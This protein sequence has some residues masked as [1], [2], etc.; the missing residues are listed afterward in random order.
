MMVWKRLAALAAALVA[1]GGVSTQASAQATRTWVSGVGDDVNPC[2]RTAPCK[3][4]AGA[5]SKTAIGGEINCLDPGGFGSVTI[6]KSLAI[7]CD[8]TE[9]GV[10]AAGVNGIVV[11]LAQSTDFVLLSGMDIRSNGTT[12]SGLRMIGIGVV[13]IRDST[14]SNFRQG[15]GVSFAPSGSASLIISGLTISGNLTGIS[16]SGSGKVFVGDSY[17]LG[18]GTGLSASGAATINSLSNNV[19]VR[20]GTDGVFATT[21]A[22]Q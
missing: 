8:N 7:V 15:N 18:N 9:A 14:I 17:I 13:H 11:N 2:S 20:N 16:A 21:Q 6:T 3:T 10:L 1:I 4:F 19:L 5:I 12:G 22:R